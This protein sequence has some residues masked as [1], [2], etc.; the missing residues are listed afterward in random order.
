MLNFGLG[1]AGNMITQSIATHESA[2]REELKHLTQKNSENCQ[3]LA[4]AFYLRK[5]TEDLSMYFMHSDFRQMNMFG[6]VMSSPITYGFNFNPSHLTAEQLFALSHF[7]ITD[8][9][10]KIK[11]MEKIKE[12][13]DQKVSDAV[14]EVLQQ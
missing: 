6:M 11:S 12:I 2:F 1:K 7:I 3:E 4:V 9:P 14:K 5:I 13:F 10:P 8:E